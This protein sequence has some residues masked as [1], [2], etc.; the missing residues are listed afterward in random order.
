MKAAELDTTDDI[1]V[2]I[3][4]RLNKGHEVCKDSLEIN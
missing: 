2:G 4:T 1:S 3:E